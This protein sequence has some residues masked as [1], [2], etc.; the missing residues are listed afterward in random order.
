MNQ[1]I[2]FPDR[3]E[4]RT[5]VSAVVFPAMVHGMQLTCAIS[6]EMLASRFG[7]DTP[8]QWLEIFQQHRWDLEEEAEGLIQ[9]QQ[10][11]AQGWVWLL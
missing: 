6:G 2:Q 10:E 4:W 1:A 5:D 7:G 3:E 8:E 11:D 9:D